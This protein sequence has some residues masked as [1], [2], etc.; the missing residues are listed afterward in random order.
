MA[1][2]FG[3]QGIHVAHV[4]VDGVIESTKPYARDRPKETSLDTDALADTYW[5][6][7]TQEKR[8]WTFELDVRPN[9]ESW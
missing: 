6:L 2:E 5:F 9:T 4:I 1:R 3:P 8:V 7:H